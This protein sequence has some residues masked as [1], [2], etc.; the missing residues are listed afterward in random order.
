MRERVRENEGESERTNVRKSEEEMECIVEYSL[1][2]KRNVVSLP[3]EN[4]KFDWKKNDGR[5]VLWSEQKLSTV[6][7]R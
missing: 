7:W 6:E 1:C 5:Q 3:F 2:L 4:Q